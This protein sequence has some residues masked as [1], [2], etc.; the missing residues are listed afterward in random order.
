MPIDAAENIARAICSDKWD[1]ER[2]SPSLF[3]GAGTSVSRLAL[4]P[5]E[6][7]WELF[8]SHVQRPP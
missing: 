8:R 1:G 6:E 4:I 3:V 2:L 7:H 5:L